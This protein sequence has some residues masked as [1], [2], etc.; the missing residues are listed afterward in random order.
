[1]K[2]FVT[3]VFLFSTLTNAALQPSKSDKPEL[4]VKN[5][6]LEI[7]LPEKSLAALKKWNKNF[8]VFN[9]ADYSPT[10]QE[11][12]ISEQN[13]KSYPMAFI[14]DVNG[15]SKEDVVLF[16]EDAKKQYVIALT[17]EKSGWNVIVVKE[18]EEK[19]LKK[20]E[21]PSLAEEPKKTKTEK[22][23][24]YYILT[25]QGEIGEKLA[26]SN[27]ATAIQVEYY[28]GQTEVYQIKNNKAELYTGEAANKKEK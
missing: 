13:K 21:I 17:Q 22:G 18:L 4:V 24:P 10:I 7:M 2:I 9:Q 25:A 20:T 12:F 16:G 1:M 14:A 27:N 28:L 5:S 11:L 19:N 23:I 15:D 8:T 6:V 3:G 26:K